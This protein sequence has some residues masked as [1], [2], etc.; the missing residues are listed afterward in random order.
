[1]EDA[2]LDRQSLVTS[3]TAGAEASVSPL[4]HCVPAAQN[5]HLGDFGEKLCVLVDGPAYLVEGVCEFV[6]ALP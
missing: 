6:D 5:R 2:A 1:M 3:A 4:L